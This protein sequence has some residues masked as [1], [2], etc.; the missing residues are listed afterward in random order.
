[1]IKNQNKAIIW[2]QTSAILIKIKNVLHNMLE[3]NCVCFYVDQVREKQERIITLFNENQYDAQIL[4]FTYDSEK[5]QN[6]DLQ[7]RCRHM[8]FYELS[9][10]IN[11]ENQCIDR[12]RRIEN[13]WNVVYVFKYFVTKTIVSRSVVRNI[14]K[15]LFETSTNLNREIVDDDENV[16]HAEIDEWIEHDDRLYRAN[17][18][19]IT[20]LNLQSLTSTQFIR[21]VLTFQTEKTIDIVWNEF[22]KDFHKMIILT[23]T[24]MSISFFL[25][26]Q[27]NIFNR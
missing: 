16:E 11:V 3:L 6:V 15:C 5:N 14:E 12:M 7:K 1:M 19:K 9:M 27:Y 13:S 21:F 26:S 2:F 23:W 24:A 8:H 17:S 4:L 10:N 25:F 18:M 20:H 22:E